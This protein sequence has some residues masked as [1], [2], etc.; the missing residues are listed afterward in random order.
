MAK[1]H[2][3]NLNGKKG[4][5][6]IEKTSFGDDKMIADPKFYWIPVAAATGTYF[7]AK[8]YASHHPVVWALGA[9]L[10]CP[11]KK[12]VDPTT[13]TDPLAL[14]PGIASGYTPMAKKLYS[15]LKAA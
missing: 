10:L 5:F 4:I 1:Y 9:L 15:H 3:K 13:V 8:H 2:S 14:P 11:V 6:G 12:E 7:V